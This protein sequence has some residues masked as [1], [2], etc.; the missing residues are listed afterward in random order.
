M[1]LCTAFL[2]ISSN[3]AL[4]KCLGKLEDLTLIA[5]NR[6]SD[7]DGLFSEDHF[8]SL[9]ILYSHMLAI[10]LWHQVQINNSKPTSVIYV[11]TITLLNG[12]SLFAFNAHRRIKR[13]EQMGRSEWRTLMEIRHVC[14]KY[15]YVL[16]TSN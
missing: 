11:K 3:Q 10:C 4:P 1:S 16:S 5:P 7:D 8:Q 15:R 2:Y 13:N 14:A 9:I 12:M 6:T